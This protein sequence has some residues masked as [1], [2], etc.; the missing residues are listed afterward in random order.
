MTAFATT[1]RR[2]TV[3]SRADTSNAV[4]SRAM[5]D[6]GCGEPSSSR[7]VGRPADGLRSRPLRSALVAAALLVAW[8]LLASAQ[9]LPTPHGRHAPHAATSAH[10]FADVARWSAVFDDPS[11][12]EWQKPEE[13]VSALAIR[14]GQT[15]ADLGAGTGYFERHLSAAVG[16]DGTVLAVEPEP[17]LVAHL[18]ER[19]EKE[20]TANV[21]PILASPD[22]PRLPRGAV[23]LVLLVDTYHH[24]D[25]RPAYFRR[26]GRSLRPSG[27]VAIVDF[28]KRDLPV[29]P[30][31]EHKLA[32]EIVI[33]EMREAGYALEAEPAILPHQYVLVFRP[34]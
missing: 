7:A 24:I 17:N 1:K 23:D 8:T 12:D 15:V 20:A 16:D 6:A 33:A 25:D 31:P 10:S 4:S 13:L 14:P 29:G 26:L 28:E 32:R 30:P 34:S 27:R 9:G 19:A 18:R 2:S 3:P 22:N 21:V 11:R 5:A